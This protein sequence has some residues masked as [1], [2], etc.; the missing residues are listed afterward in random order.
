MPAL[1]VEE[2]RERLAA[3]R[4][5]IVAAGGSP[6]TVGIVAV[7]KTFPAAVAAIALEAG[8]VDLGENYSQE[9]ASKA[10]DV[11]ALLANQPGIALP[12]W[13]FI[14][15]L[16]R[17][18]VKRIAHLVSLWQTVDRLELVTE[19][20][21]RSPGAAVLIQVNTTAEPQKSG[22]TAASVPGLVESARRL[23]LDVR[24]LMTIGPTD[25]SDPRPSFSDL[26]KLADRLDLIECSMG[27]SGD[28]TE[29]VSEGSTMVRVGT[30]L[31]GHRPPRGAG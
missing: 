10:I 27:M 3:L 19:I 23:G 24:G 22:A 1:T 25:G 12:R 9:L 6:E 14:G 7:T 30:A 16:Q 5:Q 8:L 2:V 29:A 13:H 26:R 15:G 11:A 18:K 4:N 31:F 21:N 20:A 28:V 17:N